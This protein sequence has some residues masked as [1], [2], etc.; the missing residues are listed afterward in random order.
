MDFNPSNI[1]SSGISW[2]HIVALFHSL[3]LMLHYT[4][5]PLMTGKR[6]EVICS[7]KRLIV[8]T[9]LFNIAINNSDAKNFR[10]NQTRYKRDLVY[11]WKQSFLDIGVQDIVTCVEWKPTAEYTIVIG[12]EGGT[13]HVQDVRKGVGA[14][15]T[16][17]PHT[18]PVTR[19][20]FANH[21]YVFALL[22]PQICFYQI[23]IS[24]YCFLHNILL[25]ANGVAKSMFSVVYVCLSV[26]T[27]SQPQPSPSAPV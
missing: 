27:G 17:Y 21:R 22:Q 2:I 24:F 1:P 26:Y 12:T 9:E 18:R 8:V 19:M 10:C 11:L 14:Q 20:Q 13:V 7:F 5:S 15:L 4:G 3:I 16:T 25:P 23:S 6:C